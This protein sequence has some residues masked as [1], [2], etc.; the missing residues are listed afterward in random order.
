MKIDSHKYKSWLV[1]ALC[2]AGL[3]LYLAQPF[4]VTNPNDPRF[5]SASFRFEDYSNATV[6]EKNLRTILILGMSMQEVDNILVSSGKASK[7]IHGKKPGNYSEV[8]TGYTYHYRPWL[9]DIKS[10]LLFH[11]LGPIRIYAYF[12]KREELIAFDFKGF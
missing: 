9:H 11:P 5:K 12:D 4:K 7:V 2:V 1:S 10:I 3:Y 8:S 6:L